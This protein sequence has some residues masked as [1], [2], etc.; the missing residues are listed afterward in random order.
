[1]SWSTDNRLQLN[2][3]NL[4]FETASGYAIKYY[5]DGDG[6][7]WVY[8]DTS[9][10]V[11]IVRAKTWEDAYEC[12]LD[13]IL[14]PIPQDEVYQAYGYDSAAEFEAVAAAGDPWDRPL[15]EGYHHQPNAGDG[16]GIVSTDLNGESLEPLTHRVLDQLQITVRLDVRGDWRLRNTLTGDTPRESFVS[17]EDAYAWAS[18]VLGGYSPHY[19]AEER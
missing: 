10:V 9:G 18:A 17:Y 4:R 7:L 3:D 13:E 5:D 6:G 1:M 11:G 8:R 15:A 12:V 2:P 19:R 14:N 16:T